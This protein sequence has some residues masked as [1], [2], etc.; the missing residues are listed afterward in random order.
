M[1]SFFEMWQLVESKKLFE[2]DQLGLDSSGGMNLGGASSNTG[3]SG[4]EQSAGIGSGGTGQGDSPD[5]SSQI[6]ADQSG[7]MKDG[8]LESDDKSQLSEPV[9]DSSKKDNAKDASRISGLID[10][11]LSASKSGQPLN[12]D[13]LSKLKQIKEISDKLEEKLGEDSDD[14]DSESEEGDEGDEDKTSSGQNDSELD[15][16]LDSDQSSGGMGGGGNMSGGNMS[17]GNMGGGN[18]GGGNMGG[19]QF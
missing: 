14:E 16:G 8:D 7:I 17:G 19:G 4:F 5:A 3:G 18:M 11:V 9:G 12:D 13:T 6:P 2:Q 15:L 1:K 10:D